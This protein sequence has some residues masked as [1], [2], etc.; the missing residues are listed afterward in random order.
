MYLFVHHCVHFSG[1]DTDE[2]GPTETSAAVE[3]WSSG[4][5]YWLCHPRGSGIDYSISIVCV[6]VLFYVFFNKS[7]NSIFMNENIK[8]YR[9]KKTSWGSPVISVILIIIMIQNDS[10][11]YD[12]AF[13]CI[14]QPV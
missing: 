13:N 6:D 10:C 3:G 8:E 1:G 11:A 4:P 2:R 7:I 5:P 9:I 12:S 14:F